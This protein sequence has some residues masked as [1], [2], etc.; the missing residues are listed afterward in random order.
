MAPVVAGL[1]ESASGV[2]VWTRPSWA[3]ACSYRPP[4]W[5]GRVRAA[6]W[7]ERVCSRLPVAWRVSPTLLRA[8][9][10]ARPVADVAEQGQSE[11]P[12]VR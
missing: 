10:V 11:S 5:L 3:R 4:V 9:A 6:L 7:W 12:R 8:P 1:I 2:V